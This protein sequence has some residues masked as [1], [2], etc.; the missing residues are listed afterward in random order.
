MSTY[1]GL[2]LNS[3]GCSEVVVVLR[4]K[5]AMAILLRRLLSLFIKPNYIYIL[6]FTFS[7]GLRGVA[8]VWPL[9]FIV[10]FAKVSA[11][12]FVV[13]LMFCVRSSTSVVKLSAFD[14]RS[15][16]WYLELVN[17]SMFG[18]LPSLTSSELS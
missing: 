4:S 13:T 11:L 10:D 16:L 2:V 12:R 9:D 3:V 8:K 1:L 6:I 18:L 7:E 15:S 14:F 17:A 5:T